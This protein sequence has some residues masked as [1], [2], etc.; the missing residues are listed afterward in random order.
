MIDYTKFAGVNA[1]APQTELPKITNEESLATRVCNIAIPALHLYQPTSGYLTAAT[2]TYQFLC[3]VIKTGSDL[4]NLDSTAL[5]HDVKDAARLTSTAALAVL[6]PK[7][8]TL[9]LSTYQL[10]VCMNQF[11]QHM[12]EKNYK[13]AASDLLGVVQNVACI[14]SQV[15]PGPELMVISLLT[16]ALKEV[17]QSAKEFNRG[18]MLEGLANLGFAV[19]RA[20]SAIPHAQESMLK[21]MTQEDLDNLM[22]QIDAKRRYQLEFDFEK[23]LNKHEY[24]TK[25]EGLTFDSKDLSGIFF[26]NISFERTTFSNCNMSTSFQNVLFDKCVITKASFCD[27]R[28]N[29]LFNKTLFND[30]HL[31]NLGWNLTSFYNTNFTNSNLRGSSFNDTKIN[32]VNFENCNLFEASFYRTH[33]TN[34]SIIDS[35]LKDCLFF[36]TKNDY[37]INDFTIVGGVPN[38]VTRPVVMIAYLWHVTESV[39]MAR[40]Q[41]LDAGKIPLMI[42]NNVVNRTT[43][44][45]LEELCQEKELYK[46]LRMPDPFDIGEYYDFDRRNFKEITTA[47]FSSLCNTNPR[48]RLGQMRWNYDNLM[49]LSKLPS[50]EKIDDF[51]NPYF[52]NINANAPQTK[53]AEYIEEYETPATLNTVVVESFKEIESVPDTQYANEKIYQLKDFFKNRRDFELK[54]NYGV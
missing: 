26:R 17:I 13:S 30:C 28:Y 50:G 47:S 35:N 11:Y 12:A 1:N 23:L 24:R 10:S 46:I 29:A 7:V 39:E 3:V 5:L 22:N 43:L 31:E 34:S 18:R 9:A 44:A 40:K 16:Q 15:S 37:A 52:S 8:Y 6:F 19:I 42:K 53:L 49:N 25:I 36:R 33:V 54:R 20:Y 45:S 27:P 2:C 14:A 4:I 51:K 41:I 32:K 38:E 21:K 48:G